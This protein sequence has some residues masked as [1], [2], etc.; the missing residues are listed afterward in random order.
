MEI[1]SNFLAF[2]EI[3]NFNLHYVPLVCVFLGSLHSQSV[4]K[5]SIASPQQ[6]PLLYWHC[7]LF[8][9]SL[10][11]SIFEI[12]FPQLISF[13]VIPKSL[14]RSII[15]WSNGKFCNVKRLLVKEGRLR[16]KVCL[17]YWECKYIC[18][19][20]YVIFVPPH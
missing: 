17:L 6:C 13:F 16:K 14:F 4:Q 1:P 11:T 18:S 2:S 12:A 7:G 10:Q 5:C 3:M 20:T 15:C 8:N 19:P 9:S